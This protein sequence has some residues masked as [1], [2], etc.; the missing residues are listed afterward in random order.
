MDQGDWG[1]GQRTDGFSPGTGIVSEHQSIGADAVEIS[2]R[3]LLS[4]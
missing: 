4:L 2:S 1:T 3:I